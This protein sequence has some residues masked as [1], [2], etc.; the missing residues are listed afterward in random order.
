MEV[1]PARSSTWELVIFFVQADAKDAAEEVQMDV[2]QF[3]LLFR[4]GRPC[5][6]TIDE[7][8]IGV[9]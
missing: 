8:A 4:A 1:R 2:V 3:V 5:F 7:S 6:T 9:E